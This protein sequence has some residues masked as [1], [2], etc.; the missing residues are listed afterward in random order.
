MNWNWDWW[1]RART[2]LFIFYRIRT[3]Y[4]TYNTDQ[5]YGYGLTFLL[6]IRSIRLQSYFHFVRYHPYAPYIRIYIHILPSY[7]HTFIYADRLI[8]TLCAF[9]FGGDACYLLTLLSLLDL[10][11]G[12]IDLTYTNGGNKKGCYEV[13]ACHW[14]T[15]S[16]F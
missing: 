3:Y 15:P 16:L 4:N 2:E 13:N 8:G 11:H 1:T 9:F 14:C 6:P 5:T 12:P 10:C 7:V